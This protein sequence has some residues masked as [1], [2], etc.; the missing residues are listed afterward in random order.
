MGFGRDDIRVCLLCVSD[1]FRAQS[2]GLEDTDEDTDEDTSP[3]GQFVQQWKLRKL[4]MQLL[5]EVANG[6]LRRLLA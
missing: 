1:G 6:K 5:K 3:A 2:D 4:R